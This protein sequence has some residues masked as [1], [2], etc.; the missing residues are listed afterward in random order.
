[1]TTTI[2]PLEAL[3]D[4]LGDFAARIERDLK[5]SVGSMLAELRG[6]LSALR[7]SR[8]ETELRLDRAVAARLAEL[9]DGPPGPAGGRGERGEA[10]EA[11]EGPPGVQGIPGPPGA[12]GEAGVRGEPGSVGEIGPV[13]PAGP[14]GETGPPGK[15]MPPKAWAKGIHYESALVTHEGSTWCAARDTAEEPPHDDWIVVA[16]CGEAP[17][18]GEVCGLFDPKGAY[19]KFDLVTFNGSEWR[20]KRDNPGLLPGDGWQLAGQAGSR[21]KSGDRG[22][23]GPA[24]PAAPTIIEWAMKGYHAVPIMSDGSL[25]PALDLREV[26]E[27]YHAERV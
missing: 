11:I 7:A 5:L 15:F 27:L 17:Y 9:Q 12:P 2:S 22:E 4:E 20:A 26:F 8:A 25:G 24:G 18:V 23:R 16:A 1:M 19:R 3:A 13:G 14:P 10:G 21:G 6:E